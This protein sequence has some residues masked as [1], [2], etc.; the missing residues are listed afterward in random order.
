MTP[1][2]ILTA[3]ATGQPAPRIPI[4][5]NLL[6]QGA[7]ELGMT[8]KDYYAR[9]EHVADGQLRMCARYGYDNVWSLFYV[10]KEAE[11]LGCNEILFADNGTPN[12]ADFVIKDWDDIA[13]LEV[14]ADIT[15]H[16]AWAE[17]ASC[18]NILRAEVGATHSLCA[19]ITAANTLP[20]ILMGMEKWLE[21]LLSGPADL[22]DELLRK[23][24]DLTR[25][26]LAAYRAAGANVLVYSTPFGSPRFVGHK[27]F[28]NFSMPW[29]K[30][31]LAGVDRAGL[32]YYCGMT[33]FNDVIAQ[34]IDELGIVVH[35][36]GPSADIA[37][38]KALI[39]DKG[40]TCGVIDD[41]KLIHWTPEETREE[42]RRICAAGMAGGHFLFGTG[43][44]PMDIPEVNIQIMLEAAFEY[45][46]YR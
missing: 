32:V 17:T 16:P 43:V 30:Q 20:V 35:Y 46:R 8:Q 41:I 23:C 28:Q 37:Q 21:L 40:I 14:P 1:L 5:C 45:G 42:V 38:A 13:R 22:R 7:R 3:A 31:D 12:V 19:Y 29:M 10:G 36:L 34:V 9:G 18:L 2:E 15:A 4:F 11:L 24:S 33:D 44:M 26:E 25:Q 27:R 6:D 39:G